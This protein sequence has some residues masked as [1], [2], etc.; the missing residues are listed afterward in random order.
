MIEAELAEKFQ[1]TYISVHEFIHS[2]EKEI[3]E[4]NN[5]DYFTYLLINNLGY[6]IEHEF[7]CKKNKFPYLDIEYDEISTLSFNL[8]SRNSF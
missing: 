1:K 4:L 8:N 2:W 7:F 5:L 6:Q 3:Y